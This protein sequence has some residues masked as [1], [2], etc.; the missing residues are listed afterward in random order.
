MAP[1]KESISGSWALESPAVSQT[2]SSPRWMEPVRLPWK[3]RTGHSPGPIMISHQ[4]LREAKTLATTAPPA[5]SGIIIIIHNHMLQKVTWSKT[6]RWINKHVIH[7]HTRAHRH[8][9]N[10]GQFFS[11]WFL[12]SKAASSVAL[13]FFQFC[14]L[15]VKRRKSFL[16]I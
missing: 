4:L 9:L 11:C 8:T 13:H 14:L 15:L 7:T 10:L 1:I 2:S 5:P 3:P 12:H 16:K 6:S